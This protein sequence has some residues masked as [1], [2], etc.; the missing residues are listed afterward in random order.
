[1]ESI[2]SFLPT[3]CSTL[4]D[5]ALM[6]YIFNLIEETAEINSNCFLCMLIAFYLKSSFNVFLL[7]EKENLYH[8]STILKKNVNIIIISLVT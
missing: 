3:F 1:M 4:S 7:S 8:Y 2:D 5:E 6:P